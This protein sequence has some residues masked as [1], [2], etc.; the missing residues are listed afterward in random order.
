MQNIFTHYFNT[1]RYIERIF[2]HTFLH[3][4]TW[5]MYM[6]SVPCLL[7]VS[8]WYPLR[9]ISLKQR[10]FLIDLGE[11][12][13]ILICKGILFC[14]TNAALSES[15]IRSDDPAMV[16]INAFLINKEIKYIFFI[17]I[18]WVVPQSIIHSSSFIFSYQN[19]REHNF[20]III[21]NNTYYIYKDT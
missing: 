2:K 3:E 4:T 14:N 9:C 17:K 19:K 13:A 20:N 18:V 21:I 7:I 11:Y 5:V 6:Y 8:K 1:W 15:S 10:R 12:R 16:V